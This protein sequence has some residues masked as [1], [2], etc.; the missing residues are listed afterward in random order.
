MKCKY[1]TVTIFCL[2]L[3]GSLAAQDLKVIYDIKFN[4]EFDRGRS[5]RLH[6][7]QLLL[8]KLTSRYFMMA[9]EDYKPKN[10][11]DFVFNPDT[12]VLVYTDQEKGLLVAREY[13]L[14]G[15][16]FFVSDSL[17][18]MQW[19]ITAE[20]KKID[21]FS[22]IRANAYYRGRWYTA[23]FTPDIPLPFGPWKMGGLPGLIID[24]QDREENLVI[25]LSSVT[26]TT[27]EVVI[28]QVI[29]YSMANH[30][31]EMKKFLKR[32]QDNARATSTGD[33]V[34]CTGHSTYTFYYWEKIPQ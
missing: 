16:P 22:C 20:Q 14:D 24:L 10:Q 28:P 32:L 19:E 25:R 4:D 7:G 18:P 11:N 12:N 5:E 34:T 30:I 3:T 31:S 15:K 33:C 6:T 29:K 8:N 9:K 21:S 17:Y 23:W 27:E 13:S 26:Q 2:V 1:I